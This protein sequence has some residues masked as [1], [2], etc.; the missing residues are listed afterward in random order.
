MFF[1]YLGKSPLSVCDLKMFSPLFLAY[2]YILFIV[3]HTT[4]LQIE[5]QFVMFCLTHHTPNVKLKKRLL[6]MLNLSQGHEDFLH[7]SS[8]SCFEL[9][10][11]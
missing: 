5:V 4:K 10:F 7:F 8:N 3:F 9:T 1:I 6:L 11:V 2:L